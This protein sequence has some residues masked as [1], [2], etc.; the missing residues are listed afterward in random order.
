LVQD[1]DAEDVAAVECWP[2]PVKEGASVVEQGLSI[3][4]WVNENWTTGHQ[5]Y[6]RHR[7]LMCRGDCD[8]TTTQ[9]QHR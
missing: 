4:A 7:Q 8:V 9:L 3:S 6:W 5:M 1:D 2:F